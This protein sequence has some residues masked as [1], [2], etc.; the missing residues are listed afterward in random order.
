M[1]IALDEFP[2]HQGPESMKHFLTSDR[3]V[4][5]RCIMHALDRTG[6]VQ[7]AAGLGVYPGVGVIDC[8]VAIREGR[9]L[10]SLRTSG[11]LSDDR[12][13]Q[14]VG[15]MVIDVEKA[16][17]TVS[18]RC[19]DAGNGIEVDLTWQA[20]VPATDEPRHIMRQ[21]ET[22]ILDAFRF[23]QQADV[24]GRVRVDDRTTT[25]MDWVGARDRSWGVR[26]VGDA[27]SP[28]RPFGD[29]AMWWCWIPLR[30]DDFSLMF[31]LEEQPDGYRTI[32]HAIRV[33]PDGRV[34]QLGWPEVDIEYAPG[35]RYPV[36]ARLALKERGG[37]ALELDIEPLGPM[38][39]SVGLGYGPD[40]DGWNHGRWMGEKWLERVDHDLDA[41]ATK[42]RVAW[43]M[44]DHAARAT[45]EGQAGYGIF[46]HLCIGRHDPSGFPDLMTMA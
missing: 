25:A 10:T 39:L 19:D 36:R 35:T 40:D 26:P 18:F 3:N 37:K 32:N 33:R 43:S 5:D 21:G 13:T 8:Y 44:I 34:D 30:F 28:Q 31:V 38:P 1:P 14:R 42:Q 12:M 22:T 7:V 6:E 24:T 46:E 45:L 23:V 17:E 29:H 41:E 20:A 27:T 11:S 16:L 4:Y 9:R 2:I 15:P